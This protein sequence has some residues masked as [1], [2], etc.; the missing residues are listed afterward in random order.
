MFGPKSVVFHWY[1]GPIEVLEE[2]LG[3]GYF[4]SAT[5]S[6][7]DREEHRKAIEMTPVERLLLETDSPAKNFEPVDLRKALDYVSVLKK[8]DAVTLA[9]VTTKNA[10]EFFD[11]EIR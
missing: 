7:L 10:K 2:I 5:P 8:I 6:V 3:G 9:E 4:V 1:S 11:I